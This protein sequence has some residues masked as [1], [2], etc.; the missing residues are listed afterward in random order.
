[1]GL[2]FS[3]KVVEQHGGQISAFSKGPGRGS[4]FT[5]TLPGSIVTGENHD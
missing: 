1:M 4:C 5:I 2:T 3:R